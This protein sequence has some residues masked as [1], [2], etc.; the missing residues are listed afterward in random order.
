LRIIAG[1]AK[2]RH[3]KVP[4]GWQGRPTAD[5]VKES[6]FNI[7][8]SLVPGS[9]FLDLFAGT[10][11]IGIEALSRGAGHV[12]LVEKDPRAARTIKQNI[13]DAGLESG[14]RVLTS[15]VYR[16]LEE[17]AAGSAADRQGQGKFDLVFLDPPYGMGFEL[18]VIGRVLELGLLAQ[19]G[20]IIAESG[21]REELPPDIKGLLLNRQERYGD[22]LLSFYS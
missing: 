19:G 22:T 11:N 3:L 14:A 7:L 1:S 10:G 21:K 17:L 15:D 12:V 2:K 4:P 6:L 5:R 16:A 13:R 18:P 9:V 8:G 20:L